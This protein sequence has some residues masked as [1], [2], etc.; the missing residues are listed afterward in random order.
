[1]V[2]EDRNTVLE[3]YAQSLLELT[4]PARP[5]I[6]N[7]TVIAGEN[8][9]FADGII[10]VIKMRIT[11]NIPDHKLPPLY[12]LDSICKTVGNPYNIL[13]GDEIFD[14]FSNVY[15]LVNDKIRQKLINMF[16]TWK[17]TKSRGTSL[18]LFPKVQL[19][20]IEKFLFQAKARSSGNTSLPSKPS[21]VDH[22][23]TSSSVPKSSPVPSTLTNGQLIRDIDALVPI[24]QSRASTNPDKLNALLQLR[25]LLSSQTMRAKE[26]QA[27]QS[28]LQNIKQQELG[29][30]QLQSQGQSQPQ[31]QPQS[32]KPQSQSHNNFP[33]PSSL[34]AVPT[35]S[36]TTPVPQQQNRANEL[37]QILIASGL[38]RIDQSLVAGSKPK[39]ELVYPKYKYEKS[40]NGNSGLPSTSTL[41]QLLS[42]GNPNSNVQRTE[43]DTLKHVELSKL[44]VGKDDIQKFITSNTPSKLSVSL[45]YTAKASKCGTCGKR[46]SNDTFGIQK[47]RLH[48]D[49]HFRI[50][51]K[52]AS[53]GSV[54]QCRNW[55]LDD[56][57]WVKFRDENLLEYSTNGN[58]NGDNDSNNSGNK[59]NG[60]SDPIIEPYVVIP[61]NETN[62]INKCQICHDQ[63]NATYDDDSGEWRWVNCV[64]APGEGKNSRKI[65]H[66]TC[67]NEANKKRSAEDDGGNANKRERTS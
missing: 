47:R 1:M 32:Q 10:N 22:S 60:N 42:N 46:F 57:E 63:I 23:N 40:S 54:V 37:F 65:F 19:D 18:P 16:E 5:I 36:N 51:K 28:K 59:N 13:V 53:S 17:L 12:L 27:I 49:W 30:S 20:K 33:H 43:Y 61:A 44:A 56:I 21:I 29:S 26:L 9:E 2:S 35:T 67:F 3:D 52:L 24:F 11:K 45:L 39:Y 64:K 38:V 14:I 48:L 34:P 7:L 6:D 66:A 58:T 62:M 55:Y 31:P 4:F 8:T 25:T 15:L 50:N 41:E